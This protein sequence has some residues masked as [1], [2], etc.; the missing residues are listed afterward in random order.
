M[1]IGIGFPHAAPGESGGFVLDWAR[2]AED[3]PFSSI[4]V[5]DRLVYPN[6]DPLILLSAAAAVTRRIRLMTAILL[7]PLRNPGVMA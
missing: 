5:I 7:A 3:G 1:D 2:R 4:S 6:H